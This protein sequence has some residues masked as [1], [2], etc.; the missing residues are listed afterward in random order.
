MANKD[1]WTFGR[2]L[3]WTAQYL[4]EKGSEF[5]RLDAEVL[6]AHAQGCPR[7]QLYTRFEETPRDEVRGKFKE[8]VRRRVEGCPV[9]YLVGQK[10]F[11]SLVFEVSPAVL[12]PRPDTEILALETL[13]LAK[14]LPEA[15]ALDLGTGSGAIAVALAKNH[16]GLRVTAVDLSAEALAVAARNAKKHGV[17]E[18]VVFLQGDLFAPLPAGARFDF[19]V[20]NPPYIPTSALP[21]LP[22]GVRDFEPKAALDGGPSGYQVIE[23]LIAGA[24]AFLKP[25]GHLL[26][27]IG[28]DQEQ[29]VRERLARSGYYAEPA[30]LADYAGH[31]RVLRTQLRG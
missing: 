1:V 15:T 18:R 9:A 14:A 19:I 20:S 13:R 31:P 29:P 11:F 5:P 3:D 24:P 2:L 28:I 30:T 25:K 27:E 10:E 7:I 6:L 23:R 22:P 12:I 21:L 17:A 16:A 26:L 4:A 8:L